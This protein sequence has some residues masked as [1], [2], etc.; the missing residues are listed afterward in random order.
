M[1]CLNLLLSCGINTLPLVQTIRYASRITRCAEV[2]LL[3]QKQRISIERAIPI[4]LTHN[5]IT[6][7]AIATVPKSFEKVLVC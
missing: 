6:A 1:S 5:T 2:Y 7:A 4:S 3:L